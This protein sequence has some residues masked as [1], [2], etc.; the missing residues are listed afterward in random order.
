[1]NT[2]EILIVTAILSGSACA[3]IAKEK[4]RSP[5]LWFFIGAALNV[6]VL[7]VLFAVSLRKNS[8]A[9]GPRK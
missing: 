2:Y 7:A 9:T 5:V 6:V 4:G 8:T 3:W 1:M